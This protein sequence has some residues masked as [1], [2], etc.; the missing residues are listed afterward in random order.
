MGRTTSRAESKAFQAVAVTLLLAGA[1]IA[2]W[3]ITGSLV[4]LSQALD[5]LLDIAVLGL[6]YVGIRIA[7]KPADRSHH[8]G[9]SKAEHLAVF[10][11]TIFLG[12]IVIWV[13]IGAIVRLGDSGSTVAAPWYAFALMVASA[14]IDALRVRSLIAAARTEHSD[15]LKAGALNLFGDVGTAAVTV[16]TL[17]FVR[18]GIDQADSI[19]ALVVAVVVGVAAFRLGKISVD[20]LMD[21]APEAQVAGIG[22]AANRAAGVEETRRVRVRSAGDKMFAD[23]TVA[24]GRTASLERA[25][26][27]AEA[28]ETEIG[29]DYPDTDVVVH[30][31]PISETTGLVERVQAAASR[32][33]HVH[34]I[35]NVLIHAFDEG[36]RSKLHVTL[37]AKVRSNLS[38]DEAHRVSDEIEAA[39]AAELGDGVRV[40]SHIEPMRTT[41]LGTDVTK[42]RADLVESIRAIAL[43]EPDV[44]DCHEVL[45]TSSGGDLSVTAHVGGRG[46]LPLA[47]MHD[48]SERIEKAI[49]NAHP[50]VTSVTIHFEPI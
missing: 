48:A 12:L 1:K 17:V 2:V 41:A 35:H 9:H 50:E 7:S 3:L 23:V 16:V 21:R 28:V 31:E 20:T 36:G 42:S 27:I 8:Y 10:V 13:V 30:V 49:T 19:G 26:D 46:D 40:D 32:S 18:N 29:R 44:R 14:V 33:P 38:L 15:A 6:L 5:S 47:K 4:V 43:D 22:A 37:H 39:V 34:E 24:A 25:H 45:I 11:Q